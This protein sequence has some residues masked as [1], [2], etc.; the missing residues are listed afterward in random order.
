MKFTCITDIN[1]PREKVIKLFDD[2]DNLKEWQDGFQSFEH[3]SGEPGTPGAKSRLVYIMR[4]KPME[5]IE[6]VLVRDLPYEFSGT[7]EH[8]HMT[9]TLK[10][11]FEDLSDGRT[12]WRSEC[13]YTQLNGF[14]IKLMARLFPFIFKKQVQKWNDQ[15]RDFVE[16]S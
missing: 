5:L 8:I 11:Y 4:G 3:I 15:F 6:T 2:P 10:N 9:N 12:R 16:R 14:M 7:Y 13:H 1:A